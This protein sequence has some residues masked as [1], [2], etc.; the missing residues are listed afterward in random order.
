[1]A[2]AIAAELGLLFDELVTGIRIP[3][4]TGD[5]RVLYRDLPGWSEA[6]AALLT[7]RTFP[8]Y[9]VEKVGQ[10]PVWVSTDRLTLEL[11]YDLTMI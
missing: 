2:R 7:R 5:A 4:A 11:L 3:R 9:A 10:M 6:A 8:R 1:M